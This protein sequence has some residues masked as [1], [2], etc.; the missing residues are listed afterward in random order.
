MITSANTT[1]APTSNRY[2]IAIAR[3]RG[4]RRSSRTTSGAAPN[5]MKAA[6]KKI[7]IV[8][9]MWTAT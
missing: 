4:I 2:T 9:G 3:P 1:S 6:T 8:R 7:E 5:A